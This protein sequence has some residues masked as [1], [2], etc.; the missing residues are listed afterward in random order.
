M[1]D[2]FEQPVYTFDIKFIMFAGK[3]DSL[4][5]SSKG[6]RNIEVIHC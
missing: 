1:L 6:D 4:S 3:L 5:F 2:L